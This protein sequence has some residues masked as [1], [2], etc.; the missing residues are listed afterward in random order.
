MLKNQ[1]TYWKGGDDMLYT[2]YGTYHRMNGPAYM[3][4]TGLLLFYQYGKRI[5]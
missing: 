4:K 1:V 5:C 3:I 2:R